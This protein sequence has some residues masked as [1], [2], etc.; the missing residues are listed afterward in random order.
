MSY[1]RKKLQSFSA[2][3]PDK[4]EYG[5]AAQNLI[6]KA[7]RGEKIT[8]AEEQFVCSVIKQLRDTDGKIYTEIKDVEFCK[9]YRFRSTY[10]LFFND[11]NGNRDIV[12]YDGILTTAKKSEDVN[13]L[14]NEY[15]NWASKINAQ[16]NGNDLFS[17]VASETLH[18][19]K[20]LK[21][22]S[23]TSLM[24]SRY[25]EYLKKSITLHGK[26]VFLTVKE[27]YEELNAQEQIIKIKHLNILIDPYSYVHILFRHYSKNIKKHQLDKSY[28]FDHNIDFKNIPLVLNDI[29]NCYKNEIDHTHFNEQNIYVKI[30]DTIYAIWFRKIIK[31]NKG[32]V[33]LEYLRVQTFYPVEAQYEVEKIKGMRIQKTSKYDF[34][35]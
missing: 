16:L 35:I 8:L 26:Y 28:H 1:K 18:Q 17:F 19:I 5:S 21:K 7:Y 10:I 32:N 31:N 4:L 11:L 34:L 25:F 24:G 3:L 20:I 14:H 9:N 6:N 12:D 15:Q 29:L 13:Y 33:K 22:F 23:V 2:N 30:N 27:F